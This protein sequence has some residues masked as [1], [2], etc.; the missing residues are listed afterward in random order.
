MNSP[1]IVQ[2]LNVFSPFQFDT[3]LK[4]FTH[5]HRV[6]RGHR[7]LLQDRWF[8]FWMNA[9]H[10]FHNNVTFINN[11]NGKSIQIIRH[12]L[13]SYSYQKWWSGTNVH[14]ALQ[15]VHFGFD[16]YLFTFFFGFKLIS[17]MTTYAKT[18]QYDSPSFSSIP[19]YFV[20]SSS[21]NF[22]IRSHFRYGSRF[23]KL[24]NSFIR[25]S[26]CLITSVCVCVCIGRERKNVI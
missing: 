22:T 16:V 26:F 11:T 13:C 23:G 18:H 20:N 5:T 7:L 15:F 2:I 12:T 3:S 17:Y 8:S 21:A 25:I 14:Y 6:E 24:V 19:I 4:W 9:R 1:S 10:F